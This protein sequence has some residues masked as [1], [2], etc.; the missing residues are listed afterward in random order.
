MRRP[1]F[2]SPAQLSDK[3]LVWLLGELVAIT[4]HIHYRV[5][6]S[7]GA[8]LGRQGYLHDLSYLNDVTLAMKD[9][10]G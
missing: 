4:T 2:L 10:A 8:I 5:R 1:G 6:S 3:S 7:D 9:K